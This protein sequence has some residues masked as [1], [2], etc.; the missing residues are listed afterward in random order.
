MTYYLIAGERSG[1]L[2]GANLIKGIRDSDP[3]ARFRGWGGDQMEREGMELVTHYRD[4][5]FMG[6]L[7]VAQ[8]L[9]TIFGLL[10]KCKEDI[11]ACEPDV[12][13]LIDYP[14]FNLR[15]ARFAKKNG[16]KVFYY[17]SPKVWAWNQKRALKIKA[18]VDRMFVIFPFEIDFYKKYDY[19]VDYVGNP[20]MDAVAAFR[21]DPAFRHKNGLT[22]HPI[23]ALL[24]GSRKQEISN[25]LDTMLSIRA[26]FRE[27]QF[28][29]AGVRDLPAAL[30][31][32]YTALPDVHVVYES[33]YDLLSVAEAALVTSGTATLETALLNV[34]EVVCYRTSAISYFVAKSLI[35]VPYI[36]LVNLISEKEVVKEL[37]QDE[38][39]THRL[40]EELRA[41]VKGGNRRESQLADYTRLHRL[42]GEPGASHRAGSLMVDYMKNQK[43]IS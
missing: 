27:Y 6:F 13:V 33:T 14:G 11:L 18:S 15:I 9:R 28:V 1:D 17:I 31:E 37:I 25:M 41:I 30:Y 35:K 7:E 3:E 32:K 19:K 40:T 39:N 36:S 8:N 26:H 5:A 34:P 20:L 24:P 12:V 10:T 29:I 23:I 42:V 4:T 21:P 43:G 16:L 22:D 2:H 38:L